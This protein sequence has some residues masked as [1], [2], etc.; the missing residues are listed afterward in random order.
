MKGPA[1]LW[2]FGG[3]DDSLHWDESTCNAMYLKSSQQ[4]DFR[5][6]NYCFDLRSRAWFGEKIVQ[7]QKQNVLRKLSLY[8]KRSIRHL[9]EYSS[10]LTKVNWSK[11]SWCRLA[12]SHCLL[13]FRSSRSLNNLVHLFPFLLA[14]A[15]WNTTHCQLCFAEITQPV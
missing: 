7:L 10:A 12:N 8:T 13:S 11:Y 6:K 2:F 9:N 3:L 4:G 14:V 1:Y 5:W 15:N